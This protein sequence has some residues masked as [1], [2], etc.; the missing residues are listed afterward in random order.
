[1]TTT[2][3]RAVATSADVREG[4]LL[5]VEVDGQPIVLGRIDGIAYAVDGLCPHQ[6]ALLA[7]GD[8][9]GPV[10]TCP[11]HNGAVDMRTG[12]PARLPVDSPVARYTVQESGGMVSIALQAGSES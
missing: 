9:D 1:V 5:G 7:E 3:F 6:G 8:L 12:A 2:E 10:L 4:Q 11:L